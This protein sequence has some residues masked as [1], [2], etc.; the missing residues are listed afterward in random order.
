M[1]KV[2]Y[3]YDPNLPEMVSHMGR[4]F[5]CVERGVKEFKT[6][7][8]ARNFWF[9]CTKPETKIGELMPAEEFNNG[10]IPIEEVTELEE[11]LLGGDAEFFDD[12]YE[13]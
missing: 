7:D 11:I 13:D 2:V 8:E 10:I 1:F 4:L 9:E 3:N 6:A 12:D 5:N